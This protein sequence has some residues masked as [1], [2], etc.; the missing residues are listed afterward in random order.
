MLSSHLK[1]TD[2]WHTEINNSD[3]NDL[4]LNKILNTNSFP[5]KN[6]WTFDLVTTES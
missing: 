6:Q 5:P 1:A 4:I 2:Y 3:M